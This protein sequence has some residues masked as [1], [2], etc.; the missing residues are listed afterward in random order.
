MSAQACRT[1]G[2]DGA[3][4][5]GESL[6]QVSNVWSRAQAGDFQQT[7][8]RCSSILKQRPG[9]AIKTQRKS[10]GQDRTARG[11]K[12]EADDQ[13]KKTYMVKQIRQIA[14]NPDNIF[15]HARPDSDS[16]LQ[17]IYECFIQ[18]PSGARLSSSTGRSPRFLAMAGG[19]SCPCDRPP[20]RRACLNL[21]QP[22]TLTA[23]VVT[24]LAPS[25]AALHE[26][27]HLPGAGW[28]GW[29]EID[30]RLGG[31]AEVPALRAVLSRGLVADPAR[32]LVAAMGAGR[33]EAVEAVY[34]HL[35]DLAP[36]PTHPLSGNPTLQRMLLAH[37]LRT[38]NAPLFTR[39]VHHIPADAPAWRETAG[40]LLRAPAILDMVLARAFADPRLLLSEA[41]LAVRD[42]EML[43]EVVRIA[44][45]AD[46]AVGA[47]KAGRVLLQRAA[48]DRQAGLV[49]KILRLGV[50]PDEDAESMA[51]AG[52]DR[53]CIRL[54]SK[55]RK[56]AFSKI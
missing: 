17:D 37:V 42:E 22:T 35:A 49:A 43:A 11:T 29:D 2:R 3:V 7:V 32:V 5:D 46:V 25:H 56:I 9:D 20:D 26:S 33:A 55:A 44:R 30:I 38:V 52:G 14:T 10:K 4:R 41:V 23:L 18:H 36:G 12:G 21:R 40:D 1:I 24:L 48:I 47:T 16:A 15:Q 39:A 8:R 27:G 50:V 51:Q 31:T 19:Q 54:I 45:A 34:E 6:T 53:G 28:T 13:G